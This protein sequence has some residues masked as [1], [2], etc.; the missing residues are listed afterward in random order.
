MIGP[1]RSWQCE[2]DCNYYFARFAKIIRVYGD[3][4]VYRFKD[5]LICNTTFNLRRLAC[6]VNS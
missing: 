4:W 3:I 2:I 1:I 5:I 6:D